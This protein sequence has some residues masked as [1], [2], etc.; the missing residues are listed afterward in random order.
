MNFR[1]QMTKDGKIITKDF[2]ESI[3]TVPEKR[4]WIVENIKG[5]SWKEVQG[6]F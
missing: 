2:L 5:M 3:P 1:N 4:N 6:I